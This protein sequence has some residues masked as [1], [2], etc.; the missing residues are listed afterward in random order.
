[1]SITEIVPQ[2]RTL[3]M[4][5]SLNFYTEKLGFRI[6]FNYQNFYAGLI[7]DGGSKIHLK[8]VCEKDP[9]IEY[10]ENGD[11]LHLYLQSADIS[12]LAEKL[13][14]KGV[15]LIKDVHETEWKTK[16]FI[17][18]DDQGHTLYFGESL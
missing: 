7:A 11:H 6:E 10:V 4:D 16:E 9:S 3:D 8:L 18:H 14:K 2:L 13:K 12:A 17:I 1:M 15:S 5:S